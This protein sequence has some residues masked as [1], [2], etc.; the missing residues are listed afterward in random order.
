MQLNGK[1]V[2]VTGASSGIGEALCEQLAAK[3][4]TLILSA[5]NE[6]KLNKLNKQLIELIFIAGR[7]Y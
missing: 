6:D 7:Q 4:A 2:W 5:R 3:G 1:T